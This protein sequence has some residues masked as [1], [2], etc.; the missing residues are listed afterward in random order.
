MVAHIKTVTFQGIEPSL[1]DVQVHMASG[2]PAFAIVGLPDKAVAESK[3]RVRASF[4]A[5]G[6]ALPAKRIT[7]NLSPADILKEGSHYDLPIALGLLVELELLEGDALLPYLAMGEL[8]LDGHLAPVSGVMN[9]AMA[10]FER[11]CGLL[12]PLDN[13][14]EAMSL[15]HKLEVLAAPGLME[16]VA[17][18]R[19]EGRLAPAAV[20]GVAE[21]ARH[22]L[23]L[24][25]IKGQESAKRALEVAAAGGHHL[26]M[27]GPPGAGKSMLAA[28]IPSIQPPLS[29]AEALE[30]SLIR[31]IAGMHMGRSGDGMTIPRQRPFRHPHHGASQPAVVG[32]GQRGRPGEVSLA[33]GGVLFLDELPEFS[34]STL[35]SL[36][37]PLETGIVSVARVNAHVTYPASFQLVAAMNPCRCGYLH[38]S[39]RACTR[40]PKCAVDYQMKISGP[41]MDRFD[42]VVDVESLEAADLTS[43]PAGVRS[44]EVRERVMR[45]WEVQVARNGTIKG[46]VSGR[47]P[48]LNCHLD[49]EQLEVSTGLDDKGKVLMTKAVEKY[50]LS[51]RGYHRVLR[52]AR[53]LADL[54]GVELLKTHHLAE[55]IHYRVP[56]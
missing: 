34:R 16:L 6:L 56:A 11:D 27:R 3:E 50:G 49:G 41:L 46:F 12:C 19:G 39:H 8:G 18:F 43:R 53:T 32:G 52:L 35:E 44:E 2:V 42:L 13:G 23:D 22:T 21:A 15:G 47:R 48:R 10:A 37:Q 29:A 51:A 4:S 54:E 28:R 14:A 38:D 31:S 9:A 24:A 33:H 36:R 7:V 25:D 30:V 5:L 26:L 45:A 55:A 17:H 20:S 1:I 40:A